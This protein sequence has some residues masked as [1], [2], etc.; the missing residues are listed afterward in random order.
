[1]EKIIMLG[2]G[3]GSTIDYYNTCFIIQ[4]EQGNFLVDTGGSVEIVKRLKKANIELTDINNI[5]ISH[6]HTDHILGMIWILK[7]F[8]GL[9]LN[10]K[11][12]NQI[13]VYCNDEVYESIK[14]IA[15]YVLPK[16]LLDIVYA[17]IDFHI[18]NN[19]DCIN[20]N[21]SNYTFFDINAKGFK[22]FG[23]ELK[24]NNKKLM[25]LGDE[26]LNPDL[27]DKVKNA[28]YVMHEAFCLDEEQDIFH[29]YEKHHSTV[30]SACEVMDKLDIKNLILYHTEESHSDKKKELYL[31][32]GE[33]YFKNNL[34]IPND[35]DIIEIN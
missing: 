9:Y 12:K 21:G 8:F 17:F 26:T 20:I 6:S 2:T 32:E 13:N 5:F 31:K 34:I 14:G 25:F 28:D 16:K 35:L 11:L 3:C 15:N 27:Y 33:K 30:K 24:T 10:K 22:Q 23:F 1:M 29:P 7:K 4:N 19:G 18:L